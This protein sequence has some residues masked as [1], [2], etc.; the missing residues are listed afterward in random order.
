MEFQPLAADGLT[1][2]V[3]EGLGGKR[4]ENKF[5]SKELSGWLS[6]INQKAQVCTQIVFIYFCVQKS[7]L[8]L[9]IRGLRDFYRGRG[10]LVDV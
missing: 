1:G 10:H 6:R 9:R 8:A 7:F 2:L 3:T 4:R 5:Q